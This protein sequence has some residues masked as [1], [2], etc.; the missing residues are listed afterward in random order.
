MREQDNAPFTDRELTAV[1]IV[2]ILVI[3]VLIIIAWN[4]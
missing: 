2:L 3:I 4:S 1:G